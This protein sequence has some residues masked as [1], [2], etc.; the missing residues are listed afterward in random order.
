M[1]TLNEDPLHNAIYNGIKRGIT[2]T[3][4]N[5]CFGSAVILILSAIDAMA[6]LGMPTDQESVTR[7]DFIRWAEQF[8]HF[9]GPQQLTGAD[10]YGARCAMLHSYGVRSSMSR[11]GECRLVG[12]M[13]ESYPPIQYNP[14]V[15]RELVLVSV[16]AL[17]DVLFKGI[18]DFLVYLFSDSERAKLA[19][20]R[21]KN[22]VVTYDTKKL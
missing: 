7:V 18:D 9:D 19:E 8:I 20:E 14:S 16:P 3:I 12:Y 5:H 15:S 21:L 10:L 22:L 17:R 4:D 11:K 6:Y 2:V 13:S 1:T